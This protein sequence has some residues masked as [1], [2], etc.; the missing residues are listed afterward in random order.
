MTWTCHETEWTSHEQVMNQ[1]WTSHEQVMNSNP[2]ATHEQALNKRWTS[3][4]QAMNKSWTSHKHEVTPYQGEI[5]PG[6]VA[7]ILSQSLE[8]SGEVLRDRNPPVLSRFYIW[9]LKYCRNFLPWRESLWKKVGAT[10]RNFLLQNEFSCC[11]N[12]ISV[13]GRN[14]LFS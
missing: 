2:W 1:S 10:G 14:F 8:F 3:H 5:L 9:R 7:R 13:T 6:K 11:R 12:K 4:E